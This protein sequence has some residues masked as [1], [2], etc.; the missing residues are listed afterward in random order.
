VTRRAILTAAFIVALAAMARATEEC[1]AIAYDP[2]TG[3]LGAVWHQEPRS[4]SDAAALRRCGAPGCEIRVR[5]GLCGAMAKF[6][7]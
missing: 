6:A 5:G 3:R 7:S 1:T 2:A 4:N